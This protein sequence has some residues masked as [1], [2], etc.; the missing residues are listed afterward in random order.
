MTAPAT[1]PSRPKSRPRPRSAA[2]IIDR[3]ATSLVPGR[4]P[5]TSSL[6]RLFRTKVRMPTSEQERLALREH[7]ARLD[8]TWAARAAIVTHA[9]PE[10]VPGST[11]TV[12]HELTAEARDLARYPESGVTDIGGIERW[13]AAMWVEHARPGGR[14]MPWI[15][16]VSMWPDRHLP[17]FSR[18]LGIL[19]GGPMVFPKSKLPPPIERLGA[20][21]CDAPRGTQRAEE[22]HELLK[23]ISQGAERITHLE[24]ELAA[25]ARRSASARMEVE[26]LTGELTQLKDQLAAERRRA[27]ESERRAAETFTQGEQRIAETEGRAIQRQAKTAQTFGPE[28]RSLAADILMYLDREVPNAEGARRRAQE[29]IDLGSRLEAEG[30]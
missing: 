25:A 13:L 28:L 10:L 20:S 22:V 27:A 29:L 23:P 4:K 3:L 30:K 2:E 11:A 12:A 17:G 9:L 1:R 15:A 24:A 18:A 19:L 14:F 21:I 5:S 26:A 16:L 7:L 6:V 8:P